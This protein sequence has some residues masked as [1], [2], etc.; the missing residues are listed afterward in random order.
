MYKIKFLTFT[1][2]LCLLSHT[3]YSQTISSEKYYEKAKTE[4]NKNN[5]KKA[6]E[7]SEKALRLSP[8]DMDIKEYLGKCYMETGRL[9]DARVTLLEVLEVSPNRED[10][11]YYLM[12][13]ETLS[14]RYSSA[15]CYAN[16]LLEISP[17]NKKIWI[18]K[19]SLYSLLDNR[20]EADRSTKRL[21]Q[22]FPQ[23]K[24]IKA[25]YN[26]MLKGDAA[27]MSKDD[28]ANAAKQYEKALEVNTKDPEL[29]LNLIN[30]Y[31]KLGNFPAALNTADRGIY[32]VPGN[33]DILNKKIGILEQQHEYQKALDLVAIQLKKGPSVYY[34]N[35]QKYLLS[36]SARYHNN[37]DPYVLYGKLYDQDKSNK[38]AQSYLL[39]TAIARGYYDDA[40]VILKQGLKSNPNSKEL[41]LKQFQL[42]ESRQNKQAAR[43]TIKKLYAL[44]PRDTDIKEKYDSYAFEEAKIEFNQQNYKEAIPLFKSLTDTKEYG[45]FAHQY[46]FGIYMA[47]HDYEKASETIEVLIK[48]HPNEQK[49]VLNKTDMLA[50]MGNYEDA[51]EMARANTN[52]YP[53]NADHSGMFTEVSIAYIKYLNENEDFEMVKTI[54]DKLILSDPENLNAYEYAIGARISMRQYE[55][56]ISL[57]NKALIQFPDSKELKLKLAG[58]YSDAGQ[59]EKAIAVL[60]ELQKEYPY[61][62]N[63][64][65]SL[66]EELYKN[67][68]S[69]EKN[70]DLTEAKSGYREILTLKPS[71]TL[72]AI[73]LAGILID[74]K[75]YEE[76]MIV[77]DTSLTYNKDNAELLYKKG[78]L[79]EQMGNYGKAE[80]L[81]ANY[82]PPAHLYAEHKDHLK[83]LEAKQMKNQVN[84]SYLNVETDSLAINTSVATLEYLR[85]NKNDTYI[86]RVNYG[87]RSTGI[88]VQGEIDWYHTFTNKSYFLAN[89]GVAT[90]FFPKYKGGLSYFK[91]FKNQWQV[92]VGGRYARL[93]DDRNFFTGIFGVEKTYGSVWLNIRGLIMTDDTDVYNNIL[94]QAR[95]YMENERDY[96]IVMASAGTAPED[97]RLDFQLNTFLSYVNTMVGAGYYHYFNHKTSIGVMG[98]WYNYEI[99]SDEFINQYNVFL[100]LRTKF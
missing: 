2:L 96:A 63:V 79:Y 14:K 75:D 58:A 59:S 9:D 36:E 38:E 24:Q 95:F 46:L 48:K 6:V 29:Y 97:Q 69:A 78:I 47:Q 49:Y 33:R 27:K 34:S 11:K 100:T 43:S 42:Y 45:T 12:N 80:E 3:T 89:A 32:Y 71:D 39:S 25:M 72:A 37:S 93:T 99:K 90:R 62:T 52:K 68:S 5:F 51:Y 41:L 28:L 92:E 66:I 81:Q 13:I 19:I 65:G 83:Y 44:Y 86:A 57:I 22:I 4:G 87:A 61:S 70:S 94:A 67:A 21:Y 17:Y 1:V 73:K 31:L 76:A 35:M 85:L 10:S 26:N 77:L 23:D 7:Y 40:Q 82:I 15:V 64:K 91:P 56:A 18:K 30:V 8:Q 74:T 98:N 53:D 54:S 84:I 88:G 55:E 20:V 16:E 60:K 50:T